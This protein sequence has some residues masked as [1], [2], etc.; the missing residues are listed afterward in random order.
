[1][2]LCSIFINPEIILFRNNLPSGE[3]KVTKSLRWLWWPGDR[4]DT[5]VITAVN[6]FLFESMEFIKGTTSSYVIRKY[7]ICG[8]IKNDRKGH[9]SR[10]QEILSFLVCF[11]WLTVA[12]RIIRSTFCYYICKIRMAHGVAIKSR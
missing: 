10:R 11:L 5:T 4:Y 8:I 7:S 3:D 2:L 1:M 6:N 12:W 9:Y